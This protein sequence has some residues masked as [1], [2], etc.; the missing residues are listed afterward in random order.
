M[1]AWLAAPDRGSEWAAAWGMARV[2]ARLGRVLLLVRPDCAPA[3]RAWCER[4]PEVPIEPVPVAAPA[5]ARRR[6][7]GL[8]PKGHFLD[9]WAWLDAAEKV[10]R[11]L[12]HRQRLDLAVHAALGCYWLPS[13][14][15]ELG[16]PSVWGPVGGATRTPPALLPVLGARGLAERALERLVLGLG[17]RLPATRRTMRRADLVLVECRAT[18]PVLP[19]DVAARAR[20]FNRAVLTEVP[21]VAPR[22]R[23]RFVLFPSTL[24]ARKGPML[25]LEALRRAP[26]GTA[27]LFANEG[28]EEPRLRRRVAELGLDGRA[29]FLGRV[30]RPRCFE[31]VRE[32]GCVLFAGTNEDGGCALVEAMLLGAPVVVLAHSGPAEIVERWGTDPSRALLVAP[33]APAAVA[34]GMGEAIARL[35]DRPPRGHDPHLDQAG[36]TLAFLGLLEEALAAPAARRSAADPVGARSTEPALPAL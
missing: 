16:V 18:L 12:A 8:L 28:P 10:A 15:T 5:G 4:H 26:P 32:A 31:L 7:A 21:P 25:A 13:P 1:L 29:R 20:I 35:F 30:P 22:E 6:L 34:A 9:Y 24:D 17:A 2:A 14:V 19:A 11:E 33:A 27:L 23:G 36:A 3:I